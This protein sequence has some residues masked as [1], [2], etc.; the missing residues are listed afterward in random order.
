[1]SGFFDYGESENP[2]K[3]G[4]LIMFSIKKVLIVSIILGLLPCLGFS[5]ETSLN[6]KDGVY[7]QFDTTKGQIVVLLHYKQVPIT[8]INFV[9]LAEGKIDSNQGSNKKYYDGLIFHRVMKDFMIQGGDPKGTGSGGPG[10]KFADEFV[11]GLT[12]DAPG[13]LSMANSGPGTNG[14]QFFIT[15]KATPW[16]DNKHTV[17]GRVVKGQ[18]VVDKIEKGDKINSLTILR[19]GED[20][21]A[22]K[23]DQASFD[24]AQKGIKEKQGLQ[25]KKLTA[26][27]ETEMYLRY[28]KAKKTQSGLMYVQIKQGTGPKPAKGSR[29]KVHYTGKLKDGTK[30]DSSLDRGKP[31]EFKAG[32]GQVIKG[33]DEALMDMKKGEKR[34]LMI[35]YQLAYGRKGYPGVIPPKADLIFDVELIEIN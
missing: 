26:K 22:F 6:L 2:I 14:S 18:D 35:P 27:F 1:V 5:Q 7:A 11:P 16:L 20:A 28:P 29:V 30:F 13:I 34:I 23:A 15:H 33:W 19:I 3:R 4:Q 8:V 21:K 32:V 25:T 17:F 12:H 24:A 31:I 10:Y 9:G